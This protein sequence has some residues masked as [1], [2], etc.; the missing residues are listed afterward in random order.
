MPEFDGWAISRMWRNLGMPQ[1]QFENLLMSVPSKDLKRAC[2][3]Y[4]MNVADLGIE[5]NPPAPDLD[6]NDGKLF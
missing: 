3:Y 1:T 5:E 4:R 2:A 6:D